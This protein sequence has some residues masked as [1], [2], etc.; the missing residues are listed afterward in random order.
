MLLTTMFPLL[1]QA[2][3]RQGN[4]TC[5]EALRAGQAPGLISDAL[6]GGLGGPAAPGWQV[7]SP[8]SSYPCGGNSGAR[9]GGPCPAQSSPAR[10]GRAG[11]VV[12]L[13]LTVCWEWGA[14]GDLWRN[15]ILVFTGT[16]VTLLSWPW[17]L[18]PCDGNP[19]PIPWGPECQATSGGAQV[20][21]LL[22]FRGQTPLTVDPG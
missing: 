21:W 2:G 10:V 14:W 15:L 18:P 5:C 12:R 17:R 13:K 22:S 1:P 8:M 19:H 11:R 4:V 9:P 3:D 20:G 7:V 16:D 6:Q